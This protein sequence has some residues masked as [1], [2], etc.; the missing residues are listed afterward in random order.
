MAKG[1][2]C[3]TKL[4]ICEINA[5]AQEA[6]VFDSY[7]HFFFIRYLDFSEIIKK[8]LTTLAYHGKV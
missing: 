7:K 6:S 2:F 1:M 8:E 4:F 3:V 5:L